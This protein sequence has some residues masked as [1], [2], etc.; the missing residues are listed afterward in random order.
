[1]ADIVLSARG[2][3][4]EYRQGSGL[5]TVLR[6]IDLDLATG[7]RV[8]ILGSSGSGKSTLLHLL[9]GLDRPSA[10]E[11]TLAG[12]RLDRLDPRRMARLRNRALG[13][14]YQFHHLLMEFS[15]RENV[16][17]PRVIAGESQRRALAEADRLLARVGLGDRSH[18]RPAKLS[19]GERQRV[20]IARAL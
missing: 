3:A 10:G 14:V 4:K 1:M 8:A 6:G 11:I 19:G 18:A 17:L 13:F 15:A 9:A 2:L 7:E 12:E 16:A 5:L 20:A